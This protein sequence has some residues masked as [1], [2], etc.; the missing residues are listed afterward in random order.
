ME[1]EYI[2]NICDVKKKREPAGFWI[3]ELNN[4]IYTKW[5]R[6]MD[7]AGYNST[8]I[9]E[10]PTDELLDE[11]RENIRNYPS[12]IGCIIP[13]LDRAFPNTL[14]LVKSQPLYFLKSN[15]KIEYKSNL[16]FRVAKTI[17]DLKI[18]GN[19]ATQIYPN[20]TIEFILDSFAKDLEIGCGTYYMGYIGDELV[21]ISQS[22]HG[23]SSAGIYWVGVK[24]EHRNKGYGYDITAKAINSCIENGYD[25]FV[26]AASDLGMRI[27]EK[28]G[29]IQNSTLYKYAFK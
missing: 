27:Y 9:F 14:K 3:K 5:N 1:S 12:S 20:N 2:N 15:K 23:S 8:F 7:N 24:N 22:V 29:F 21:A 16:N 19:L 4:V 28:M 18:W 26:L 6:K 13:M 25:Y 11:I 17:E 10:Y